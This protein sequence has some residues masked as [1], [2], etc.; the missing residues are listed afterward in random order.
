[1][2]SMRYN[3]LQ[4]LRLLLDPLISDSSAKLNPDFGGFLHSES[5]KTQTPY[6][7]RFYGYVPSGLFLPVPRMSGHRYSKSLSITTTVSG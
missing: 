7:G 2:N 6:P 3:P 4:A 5:D 1:M